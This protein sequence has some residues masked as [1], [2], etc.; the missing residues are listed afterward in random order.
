MP[1][2]F[3][4]EIWYL[5]QLPKSMSTIS[6][7]P[8][9][10]NSKVSKFGSLTAYILLCLVSISFIV[11]HNPFVENDIIELVESSEKEKEAKDKKLIICDEDIFSSSE[12]MHFARN[13]NAHTNNS[14]MGISIDIP[15][16]PPE[17]C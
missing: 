7:I 9:P 12:N 17:F 10:R 14:P 3:F 13:L 16:P 2:V 15:T 11:E 6:H 8:Q 4:I 5:K 1:L